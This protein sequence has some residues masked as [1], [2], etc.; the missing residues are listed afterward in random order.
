MCAYYV[1]IKYTSGSCTVVLQCALKNGC[2][3][4]LSML[5]G[6]K[7]GNLKPMYY[8]YFWAKEIMFSMT[9]KTE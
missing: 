2:K 3:S 9:V 4:D 7:Q 5:T 1:C 6:E 8:L